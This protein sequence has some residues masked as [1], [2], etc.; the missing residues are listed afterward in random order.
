MPPL[1][2]RRLIGNPGNA[3]DLS[4]HNDSRGLRFEAAC[5][6]RRTPNA[7]SA[8]LRGSGE[9]V[10]HLSVVALKPDRLT[11][12]ELDDADPVGGG[13]IGRRATT[14]SGLM[15]TGVPETLSTNGTIIATPPRRSCNPPSQYQPAQ[16]EGIYRRPE[17]TPSLP[18]GPPSESRLTCTWF[19]SWA[20][21][22]QTKR[23]MKISSGS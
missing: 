22:N 9:L 21:P 8:L 3:G 19:A 11:V 20:A 5:C 16:P 10:G 23:A 18:R 7:A 4:G 15:Y 13:R 1:G 14:Y 6:G 2:M 12:P 17:P